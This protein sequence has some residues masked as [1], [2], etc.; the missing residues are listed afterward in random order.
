[1]KTKFFGALVIAALI[2]GSCAGPEGPMGPAGKDGAN[3]TDGGDGPGS[4]L[5][6]QVTVPPGSAG[7]M[8]DTIN[9]AI[10]SAI[11]NG[12]LSP[13]DKTNPGKAFTLAVS[14]IRLNNEIDMYYLYEAI[15]NA[16]YYVNLDL[17]GVEGTAF[18]QT[19]ITTKVSKAKI[20]SVTLGSSVT[21]L[22][23]NGDDHKGTFFDFSSLK[24]IT[25]PGVINAGDE[26]FWG[27]TSLQSV[28]L[29]NLTQLGDL[30]F[31]E[32]TS[33][34]SI[35][36]PNVT[37]LGSGTFSGCTSLQ[38]VD[39]PN[40]TQLDGYT[41]ADCTSLQSISL[42]N[43]TQLGD[44]TF[45]GCTSL[46]T[47]SLPNVTQLGSGTFSGCTSLQSVNL[48]NVTQLDGRTF[49]NCTSLQTVNLGSADNLNAPTVGSGTFSYYSGYPAI[50]QTVT[51]KVPSDALTN[52]GEAGTYNESSSPYIV[53]WANGFRGA[54]WDGS[55]FVNSDGINTNI[56]L[57]IEAQ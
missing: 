22:P 12:A 8:E 35:S 17:S 25:A 56:T 4:G 31:Y 39:L 33:L 53:N 40:L 14:G 50:P 11:S 57:I 44:L 29:P 15:A 30:T 7:N 48:P 18:Q 23:Y 42:P 26:T 1:M 46:Q 13:A 21:S 9:A 5:T 51:V 43:V 3:G 27:C 24:T 45:A 55:G 36:L 32:C 2:L 41:F 37:Q 20:L 49:S 16:D 52:Y 10:Q 6:I 47:I 19:G 54:G 38:S 34:Q 28:D